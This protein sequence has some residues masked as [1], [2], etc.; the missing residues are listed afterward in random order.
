MQLRASLQTERLPYDPYGPGC[1]STTAFNPGLPV[2]IAF[3]YPAAE[4]WRTF[5]E[6][7]SG[8]TFTRFDGTT[9]TV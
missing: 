5:N 7:F 4:K 2:V 3:V 1:A 6:P 9:T 8:F